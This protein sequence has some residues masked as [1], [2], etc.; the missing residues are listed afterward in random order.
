VSRRV[1]RVP[2]RV[3]IIDL[4]HD[5]RGVARTD[6]KTLFVS[7]ALPGETVTA[8]RMKRRR[9]HDEARLV[10]VLV[11]AGDRVTPGCEFFGVCGGCTLQHLDGDAQIAAKQRIL[12]EH[13]RES[14]GIEPDTF[15]APIRAE[16][17]GYRRRAR[18]GVRYVEGKGRVL[19]GFRERFSSYIADVDACPVLASPADRL[20]LPLADLIGELTLRS[21]LP[22]VELTVADNRTAL[23]FRVLDPP[24]DADLEAFRAFRREFDVDVYLQPGGLDTVEPLDGEFLPLHYALPEFGLELGVG[25]TD[26][27]Q[28]NA[29]VNRQLVSRAVTLLSADGEAR[30]LDLF[31]GLGNFTLPLARRA[32]AVVGVEGDRALVERAERNAVANGI[33]NASFQVADLFGECAGEGWAAAAYDAVLVDPP[34]AGARP[35]L[36]VVAASGARRVVYVSC[37][38]ASLARDAGILVSEYGFRLEGAGVVDMFPHTTHLESIALFTRG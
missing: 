36:P 20:I 7:D 30:V 23:V 10:E 33:A 11:P 32:G 35:V 19:V 17:G 34:R 16:P 31:C 27:L 21:R 14:G 18:L 1:E 24:T 5:G 6:G 22:Q 38:P 9:S 25:P 4:T 12:A 28:V 2:E 8:V 26:F 13:L 3:E 37:N 29:V 15:F